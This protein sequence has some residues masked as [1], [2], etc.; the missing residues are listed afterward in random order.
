MP[1]GYLR[2]R[3]GSMTE[4]N[5]L[6]VLSAVAFMIAARPTSPMTVLY[7]ILGLLL[8]GFAMASLAGSNHILPLRWSPEITA[9]GLLIVSAFVAV[10]DP[11]VARVP[12]GGSL[13]GLWY[14]AVAAWFVLGVASVWIIERWPFMIWWGAAIS[15]A[16]TAFLGIS[17]VQSTPEPNIDVWRLHHAAADHLA[18]GDSPYRDLAVRDDSPVASEN[19]TIDGYPYPPVT[20][21]AYALGSWV[22]DAR[23]ASLGGWLIVL[24][25]LI[26]IVLRQRSRVAGVALLFVVAMQPG[27]PF[28]LEFSWTEPITLAF[29]A[30]SLASWNRHPIA[31][32]VFLGLAVASK[33]Y[34]AVA[35]LFLVFSSV[36][37]KTM[38]L[39]VS[40]GVAG[41]TFVPFLAI[42][43][44]GLWQSVV[45]FF[46]TV[47]PRP[48]GSNLVG[49]L[50]STGVV[51]NP[52][53]I[54]TVFVPSVV[55]VVLARKLHGSPLNLAMS[56]A[57]VL[58]V[59]FFLGTQAFGNYW[60]LVA[61]I[62][63]LG[64]AT[65]RDLIDVR[66]EATDG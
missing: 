34:M 31:S 40:T 64:L 26:S 56:M 1:E 21:I 18:E 23:W 63:V 46:L 48:D 30:V 42:D 6:L 52:H 35:I 20:L 62:L 19:Q 38:R 58:S 14:G 36:D 60:F 28:M 45:E 53:T 13:F 65:D 3:H 61:M 9:T 16:T 15:L 10:A 43:P 29:F 55:T 5:G 22:G 12:G 54:L 7:P 39:A 47:P 37:R 51:W 41:L 17:L 25:A 44:S 27:W 57:I 49:L 8:C 66:V 2:V 4:S 33:Q 50:A 11:R 24:S 59:M 32:S